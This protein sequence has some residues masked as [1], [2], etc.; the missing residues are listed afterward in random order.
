MVRRSSHRFRYAARWALG[1]LLVSLV[2]AVISCAIVFGVWYPDPWR[3][4]L[5]VSR[6][7]IL[8]VIADIVCGPLL[9]MVLASPHKSRREKWL[10]LSLVAIIQL[11]VLVYG[12]YSAFSARPVALVF[13]VDRFFIVTANEVQLEELPEAL[14]PFR[15]LP[16]M[17]PVTMG[18]RESTS[19]D[20][21]LNSLDKTLNGV[22]QAMRPDWWLPYADVKQAV[23]SRALPLAELMEKRPDQRKIL[24]LVASKSG[25]PVESVRF[26]PLTSSKRLDWVVLLSTSGDLLDYAQ[27]DGFY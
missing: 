17:G 21:Y 5:G 7:L 14:P 19:S 10:D 24:Q 26:L 11:A 25:L 20:E 2:V 22:S 27:V 1:H 12:L 13:E 3:Q 9:T 4:M 8:V 18:L 6:I 23:L 15:K 16:W